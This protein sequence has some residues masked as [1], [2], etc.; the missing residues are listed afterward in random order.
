MYKSVHI[1]HIIREVVVPRDKPTKI[2]SWSGFYEKQMIL[3]ENVVFSIQSD[4]TIRCQTHETMAIAF[5]FFHLDYVP[6]D[7][8]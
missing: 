6:L 1:C 2:I 3:D 5:I 7:N 8:M 4:N